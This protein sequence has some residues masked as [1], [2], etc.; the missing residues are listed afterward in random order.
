MI[1]FAFGLRKV[2]RPSAG[3]LWAPILFAV[4]GVSLVFSGVFVMDPM[5]GY[6]EG[7]AI[8][9]RNGGCEL[10]SWLA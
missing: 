7:T 6:P 5:Q 10:A 1:A 2:L 8:W 3:S 4:F 9:G